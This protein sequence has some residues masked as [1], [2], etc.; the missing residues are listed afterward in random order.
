M[1]IMI[2]TELYTLSNPLGR[3]HAVLLRRTKLLW[4]DPLECSRSSA[5]QTFYPLEHTKLAG[6][7]NA[8][9]QK[10]ALHTRKKDL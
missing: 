6:S 7:C 5:A 3:W 1:L 2:G 9:Q 10:A 8:Q 4:G